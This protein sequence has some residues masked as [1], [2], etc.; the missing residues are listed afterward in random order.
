MFHKVKRV[1]A[2]KV[3]ASELEHHVREE[4]E[5]KLVH[6]VHTVD[7]YPSLAK[8]AVVYMNVHATS[9]APERNWSR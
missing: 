8:I 5:C 4:K 9:C 2:S 1:P 6:A 3:P 7:L